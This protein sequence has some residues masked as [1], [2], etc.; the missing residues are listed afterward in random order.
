M[1]SAAA[2]VLLAVAAGVGAASAQTPQSAAASQRAWQAFR[3]GDAATPPAVAPTIVTRGD[4]AEAERAQRAF[5]VEDGGRGGEATEAEARL[6]D[7][8]ARLRARTAVQV[9]AQARGLTG[10]EV[11]GVRATEHGGRPVFAVQVMQR[12]GNR[13]DAFLVTTVLVDA[14]SGRVLGRAER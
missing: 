14:E 10:I 6:D 11:V 8:L 5:R 13:N 3:A 12:G 7:D 2:L 4:P 9:D 1:R